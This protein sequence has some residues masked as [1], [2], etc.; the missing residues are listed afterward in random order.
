MYSFISVQSGNNL[1][2]E[3]V[4]I[5]GNYATEAVGNKT[6]ARSD[7]ESVSEEK[8]GLKFKKIDFTEVFSPLFKIEVGTASQ[9]VGFS[10]E[11]AQAKADDHVESR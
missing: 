4:D 1:L 5:H 10:A 2:V 6:K 11:T 7:S 8:I 3:L 9:S